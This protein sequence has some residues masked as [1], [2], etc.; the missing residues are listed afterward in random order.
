MNPMSSRL[1]LVVL[2]ALGIVGF[3]LVVTAGDDQPVLV[4]TLTSEGLATRV[5]EGWEAVENLPFEYR[6]P[7]A[8][9]PSGFQRWM[10]ARSCGPQGC[11]VRSLAQWM[12]VAPELPTFTTALAPD[13]GLEVIA[14][15]L[16]DDYWAVT[17]RTD[18]DATLVFV[19][20]FTDGADDYVECGVSIG[21]TGD[22]RLA[23][24]I[25]EVCRSTERI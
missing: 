10:V 9:D 5:P 22:Q 4:D 6:P 1:V 17:A 2:L 12:A 13:S 15:D 23:E 21:V 20:V 18:A 16:G 7:A 14:N 25:V 11:T 19:A 8:A 24:R 3:V